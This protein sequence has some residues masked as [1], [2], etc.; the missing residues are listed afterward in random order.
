M[1]VD[2]GVRVTL[3]SIYHLWVSPG[4]L[5]WVVNFVGDGSPVLF[6]KK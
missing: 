2:N 1:P 3:V 5:L 6:R 4:S